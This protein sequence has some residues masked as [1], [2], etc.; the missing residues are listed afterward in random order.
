MIRIILVRPGSTDYDEQGRIKG[1]LDIPLSQIGE[2]QITRTVAELSGHDIQMV[3][4]CPCQA[5]TETASAIA[6]QLH[7]RQKSVEALTN[8]DHGLW[9]GKLID[10]V[11]AS[12]PK[13]YRQWQEQPETVCP[14]EGE[15]VS[16]AKNRIRSCVEKLVK[17]H[18]GGCVALVVPEPLASIVRCQLIQG[19]LGDFWQAE[20]ECGSWELVD[21]NLPSLCTSSGAAG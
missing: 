1:N 17:K 2:D 4:T 20:N 19:E 9:Q 21:V 13:V 12:Q 7:V 14:P 8:L 6:D 5:A 15:M 18:R 11:K 3:Y 10:E 16:S